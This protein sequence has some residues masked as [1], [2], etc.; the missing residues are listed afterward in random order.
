MSRD[1]EH[2][3]H[4][5]HDAG[6]AFITEAQNAGPDGFPAMD[7]VASIMVAGF[8]FGIVFARR[9][10]EAAAEWMDDFRNSMIRQ[11]GMWQADMP[12]EIRDRA[13]AEDARKI[14]DGCEAEEEPL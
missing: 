5:A 10:P 1:F 8:D 3:F 9:H 11:L 14:A 4:V 2:V 13:M 12:L 7:W 6:Q